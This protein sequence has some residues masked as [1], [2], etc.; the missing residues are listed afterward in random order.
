MAPGFRRSFPPLAS[1]VKGRFHFNKRTEADLRTGIDYFNRAIETDPQFALAYVGLSDSYNILGSMVFTSVSR[2]D[3][4]SKALMF[5]A[6]ALEIDDR[7]GEAHASLAD[8]KLLFDCDWKGS[9]AEFQRALALSPNYANAHHWYAELLIDSGRFEES[10]RES[11]RAAQLDP[12]SAMI[13]SSLAIRL[14]SA[15]RCEDALQPA[16]TALE[17]D[18]NLPSAHLTLAAI[19]GKQDKSA[20]ALAETKTAVKLSG[21]N[22]NYVAHLAC[23]YASSGD[24]TRAGE[25]LE[26]L[27][28]M[29]RTQ[30]VAPYQFAVIYSVLG[31]HQKALEALDRAYTERSPWLNNLYLDSRQGGRLANLRSEPKFIRLLSIVG[32][33]A[34]YQP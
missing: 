21:D 8:A 2:E 17:L 30:Y 19:Y 1:W 9:E 13:N 27:K 25:I 4:K 18:P 14:C 11:Y 16:L 10:L 6:K 22:P 29:S 34:A 32:P 7:L 33:P 3:A 5:A 20:E 28:V 23:V 24:R 31:N 15:N 26:R 12:L